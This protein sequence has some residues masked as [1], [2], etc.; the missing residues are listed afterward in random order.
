[1][2]GLGGGLFFIVD[3][4]GRHLFTSAALHAFN[5]RPPCGSG[6]TSWQ[7]LVH[8]D[9]VDYVRSFCA[10]AFRKR[11]SFAAWWRILRHDGAF[12]WAMIGGAPMSWQL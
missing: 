10:D 3:V 2:G 1:M 11:C 7:A 8:P 9:D 5:G 12:V 6:E 4:D